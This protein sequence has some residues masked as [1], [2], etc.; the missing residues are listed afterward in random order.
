MSKFNTP[1]VLPAP[2]RF[3]AITEE[4]YAQLEALALKFGVSEEEALGLA[5]EA[6]A[7]VSADEL[8]LKD[9]CDSAR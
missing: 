4:R 3:V 9:W 1:L 6:L 2:R 8:A 5:V 7:E